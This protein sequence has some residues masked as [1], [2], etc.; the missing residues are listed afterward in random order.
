M[1]SSRG[2]PGRL[3]RVDP[4]APCGARAEEGRHVA[5]VGKYI[6]LPDAY[7][8]VTEAL[9]AGGFAHDAKVTLK[10]VVSDDCTTP[11]GAASSARRHGRHLHPAGSASVAS[12]ASSVRCASPASRASRRS[13]LCLGLQCMVIEYAR[14]EAGLTDASS[15][16]FDPETSTPVIATMAEQVDIIAGGDLGGTMRLGLY[17]ATFTPG[18]LA[19]SLYGAP[20]ASSAT[21]TATRS[22]TRTGS[23]SRTPAWCSRVPRPTAPWSS[24]SSC[25][26]TVTRSTSPRRRTRAALASDERLPRSRGSSQPRSSATSVQPVRPRRTRSRSRNASGL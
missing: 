22:A 17:P 20:E 3:D 21:V 12:R 16:E 1:R 19:E 4:G 14:H 2:R 15:T 5:L 7:L 8:S 6:D 11:E 10:W 13:G 24:T 9:R 18:S 26:A 25:R 23:R